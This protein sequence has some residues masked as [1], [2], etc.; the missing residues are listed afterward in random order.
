M[1]VVFESVSDNE[2]EWLISPVTPAY[3]KVIT[4]IVISR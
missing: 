1:S 2:L 4:T 3:V